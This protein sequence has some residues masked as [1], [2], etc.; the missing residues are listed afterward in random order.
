MIREQCTDRSLEATA[1][2]PVACAVPIE[3]WICHT[4]VD[5]IAAAWHGVA[6]GLTSSQ[7]ESPY[8]IC[9][10][11]DSATTCGQPIGFI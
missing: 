2:L 4:K 6:R 11:V 5:G 8:W 9:W 3:V 10:L 1:T 7:V